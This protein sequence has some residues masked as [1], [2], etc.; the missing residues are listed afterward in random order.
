MAYELEVPVRHRTLW[1]AFT[2]PERMARAVPGLTVDAVQAVPAADSPEGVSGD[3]V[4]GRLKL[5]VGGTGSSGTTITYRGTA[6]ISAAEAQAGTLEVA[7]DVAQARGNGAMAGA[8]R[9]A[10]RPSGDAGEKTSVSVSPDLELSGRALDFKQDDLLAAAAVLAGQWISALAEA[11]Q[12][13][14]RETAPTVA[15]ETLEP[16]ASV[17]PS[18]PAV[19][20]ETVEPT[21]VHDSPEIA[22]AVVEAAVEAARAVEA[23]IEDAEDA[24]SESTGDA[25]DTGDAE[26]AEA[27]ATPAAPAAAVAPAADP[28]IDDSLSEDPLAPVWRGEVEKDLRLPVIAAL[29]ILL[30]VR[31][32]RRR[33][34]RRSS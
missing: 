25:D 1:L 19:A 14:V 30:L 33:R 4:A 22:Q 34:N 6:R 32:R 10:L 15:V 18:G 16:V 7:V 29:T 26:A 24:G 28:L 21:V 3:V 13:T 11:Y 17:E 5:R 27:A 23:S 8:L 31:R 20:V 2:D 12:D 9:I